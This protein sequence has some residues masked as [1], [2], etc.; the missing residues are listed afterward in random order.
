MILRKIGTFFHPQFLA[1]FML[2]LLNPCMYFDFKNH[3]FRNI[4]LEM[5]NFVKLHVFR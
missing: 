4:M 1:S 3:S 5:L 2:N